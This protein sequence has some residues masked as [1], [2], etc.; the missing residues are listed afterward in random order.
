VH[1]GRAELLE[2]AHKQAHALQLADYCDPLAFVNSIPSAIVGQ[3]AIDHG[4]RG[5]TLVITTGELSG[6]D[7]IGAAFLLSARRER[8]LLAGGADSA[9]AIEAAQRDANCACAPARPARGGAAWLL[10]ERSHGEREAG[11]HVV[12][13][14][15][16]R[17]PDATC[18]ALDLALDAAL[19]PEHEGH[20]A[21][22]VI[23][24]AATGCAAELRARSGACVVA[25]DDEGSMA[26]AAGAAASVLAV[27]WLE[28][29]PEPERIPL[30]AV[31]LGTDGAGRGASLRFE[32]RPAGG[33]P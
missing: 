12:A 22:F 18:G 29:Q 17:T 20:T 8:L 11:V 2:R 6:I 21:M 5:A 24:G 13:Y 27:K 28:Q 15:S 1:F 3:V 26:G 4:L 30:G 31:V 9:C 19:H 10:L 33:L 7:A 23:S 16:T 32:R 25:I 14:T